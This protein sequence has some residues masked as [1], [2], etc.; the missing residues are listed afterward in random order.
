[1]LKF[2]EHICLKSGYSFP[3]IAVLNHSPYTYY[4]PTY[5]TS[6]EK[7]AGPAVGYSGSA[8]TERATLQRDSQQRAGIYGGWYLPCPGLLVF[9]A[10]AL[11]VCIYPVL[12]YLSSL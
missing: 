9:V 5:L 7:G 4:S 6:S 2:C 10:T 3:H 12:G 1:M 11:H 8:R